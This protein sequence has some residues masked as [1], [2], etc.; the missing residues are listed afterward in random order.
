M[1]LVILVHVD[2]ETEWYVDDI[3]IIAL[4]FVRWD[5]TVRIAVTG[6]SAAFL[7]CS[8]KMTSSMFPMT[9]FNPVSSWCHK[10]SW[11]TTTLVI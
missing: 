5:E 10:L 9:A 1:M 7:D 6:S 2:N 11:I 4:Q 3:V 8:L